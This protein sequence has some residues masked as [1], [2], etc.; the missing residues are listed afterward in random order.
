MFAGARKNNATM[1]YGNPKINELYSYLKEKLKATPDGT[2]A[3]NRN[4]CWNLLKKL[5]KDYPGHD[6]V[7]LVKVLI[8]AGYANPGTRPWITNFG[9]IYRNT[10]RLVGLVG[11]AIKADPGA[12]MEELKRRFSEGPDGG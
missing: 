1:T 3:T 9:Y 11:D 6:H 12:Q 2:I 8:D 10:Q 7:K 4:A 5:E